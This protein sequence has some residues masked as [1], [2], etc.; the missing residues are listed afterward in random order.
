MYCFGW[1]YQL[2]IF[3][4]VQYLPVGVDFIEGWVG[5]EFGGICGCGS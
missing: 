2:L 4:F 3:A 1:V 5:V